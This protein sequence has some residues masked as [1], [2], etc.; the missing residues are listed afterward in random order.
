[1]VRPLVLILSAALLLPLSASAATPKDF[2]KNLFNILPPGQAGIFPPVTNSTDQAKLYDGL[3]P[4][5]DQVTA[6]D[7][8]KYFKPSHFGVDGPVVKTEHP[9]KGL[10]IQ[11]DSY[12]VPHIYGKTRADVMF[13]SGWATAQDRSLFIET[14]RGPARIAAVDPPGLDALSVATQLRQFQPTAATEKFIGRQAK[15]VEKTKTGRALAK[16]VDDYVAGINAWYRKSKNPAK[17]WT[18]TDVIAVTALLGQ[19]FGRGGGNEVAASRLLG[20]LQA[21]FGADAGFNTWR[22]LRRLDDPEAPTNTTKRFPYMTDPGKIGPGAAIVDPAATASAA[23]A[24]LA[25][26]PPR[27]LMSNALLVSKARSA[28]GH[29]LGVIGAQLGYYYPMLFLELD[30]HGGGFDARG[31]V[32]PGQPYVL[33]GHA[34]DYAWDATSG[35]SDLMDQFL[36]QLCNRDGSAPTAAS[37]AYM[38]KG[39]CRPMTTFDAGVLKGG[40][41]PDQQ[42]KFNETVHG[43]VAGV[44]TV[45]GKPYAVA[46]AR[47]TR[48]RE[49]A[50]AATIVDFNRNVVHSAKDFLRSAAKLEYTFNLFYI[51][52]KDIAWYHAC[53]CPIRA[54]G[55]YPGVPT[56]GT[57]QYDWRG[58]LTPKQ[59][60]QAINPPS[61][62]ILDW[63][64]KPAP[65]WGAADDNWDY[66]SVQRKE[67]FTGLTSHQD[68]LADVVASMN[69]AATQDVKAIEIWPLISQV[70]A[71][72]P[73][74]D[75]TTQ[76]AANLITAWVAAGGSRLDRDLDGKVDDPGAAVMDVAWKG[77]RTAVMT[78]VLGDQIS[79]QL[80]TTINPDDEPASKGG[81]A[82]FAGWYG[83]VDKD[84]RTLLGQPVTGPFS[85]RYCGNGDLNACRDALWAAMKAAA[86]QLSA[87]QG[88][89][90]AAWRSDAN[91]ER[92]VFKPGL[93]QDTM[94]WVNRTS[95]QQV[96][97]FGGHRKR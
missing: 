19:T 75:A 81:G 77:L 94:R 55:T 97:E 42:V 24:G 96:V 12:G 25:P 58:F 67:L 48:G 22:D 17:P 92:I 83:Y 13:G 78:P 86:D 53:R 14:I 47:S 7:I 43:P 73:A 20:A 62:V 93:L 45:G 95:F 46:N 4:L 51:D 21:K 88:P 36:E 59:H 69:R 57:G 39:K 5:F 11:R 91:A 60:P 65:G 1:M 80:A 68:T 31:G 26:T 29:P 34:K 35:T 61:G 49:F 30:L 71:T 2:G 8:P 87:A 3:T 40:N 44:V 37:T 64:S 63:N 16:D 27:H 54:P 38:Y 66:G 9:R 32:L 82:F 28:T 52:D 74:P 72:G 76:Q 85:R 70:L 33:L 90:P 15:L 84:L 23:S 6:A 89:D 10:T 18:R 41:L 56:L 79:D 50:S